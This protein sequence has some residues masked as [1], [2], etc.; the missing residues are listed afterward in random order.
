MFVTRGGDGGGFG[1]DAQATHDTTS[2]NNAHARI[3]ICDG[4]IA[5]T[6]A[7]LTERE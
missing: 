7:R 3:D 1:R 2:T 5:G 4:Y 6:L